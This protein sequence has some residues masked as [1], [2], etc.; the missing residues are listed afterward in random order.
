MAP[1]R[2]E[3]RALYPADWPAIS[4]WVKFDRAMGRCECEGECESQLHIHWLWLDPAGPTRCPNYHR[5]PSRFTGSRVILTTA[6]LEHNPADSDSTKLR[7]M[8]QACHLAYDAEHHA[9]TRTARQA[10]SKSG[11]A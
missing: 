9:T 2:A 1:I 3:M 11:D 10:T 7:A 6:H 8:C 4:D 5:E